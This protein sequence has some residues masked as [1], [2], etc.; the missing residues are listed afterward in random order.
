MNFLDLN[1]LVRLEIRGRIRRGEVTGTLLAEQIG[2]RQA[3]ISNYLNHK[4]D[5]SLGGLDRLLAAQNLTIEGLLSSQA[6]ADHPPRYGSSTY[7]EQLSPNSNLGSEESI[8][9]SGCVIEVPIVSFSAVIEESQIRPSSIIET[10]PFSSNHLPSN[11]SYPTPKRAHWQRF[12]AIRPDRPQIVA[13][14]PLFATGC[15]VVIDRHYNSLAHSGPV[16]QT[17][18]PTLYAV[19]YG[20]SLLLRIVEFDSGHLILRAFAM[21]CP[22]QLI[23]LATTETLADYLLGRICIILSEV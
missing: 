20:A 3:H 7:E 8:E 15:V 6:D 14:M 2:F 1:E 21:D 10:L 9:A 4:R 23:P 16:G 18:T 17:D 11:R 12:V 13:M 19:R 22:T 5:L